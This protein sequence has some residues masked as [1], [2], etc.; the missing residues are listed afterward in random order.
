MY[1][2]S[3]KQELWSKLFNIFFE[4][5]SIPVLVSDGRCIFLTAQRMMMYMMLNREEDLHTNLNKT[6]V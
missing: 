1:T 5:F 4:L 6:T 3:R 2:V